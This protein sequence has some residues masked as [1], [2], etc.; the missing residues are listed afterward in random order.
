M[1]NN[2][3]QWVSGCQKLMCLKCE[4]CGSKA[5]LAGNWVKCFDD[6]QQV[7]NHGHYFCIVC[8]NKQG[9]DHS[10]CVSMLRTIDSLNILFKVV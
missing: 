3:E 4:S 6:T 9:H 1:D 2:Y 8:T 10:K 5:Y 7:Y